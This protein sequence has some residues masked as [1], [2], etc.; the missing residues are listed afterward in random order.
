MSATDVLTRIPTKHR[1]GVTTRQVRDLIN[2][3]QPESS[4]RSDEERDPRCDHEHSPT[5]IQLPL[6]ERVFAVRIDVLRRRAVDILGVGDDDDFERWHVRLGWM[7]GRGTSPGSGT[8]RGAADVQSLHNIGCQKTRKEVGQAQVD[9]PALGDSMKPGM[10][11]QQ[12]VSNL[13]V[14]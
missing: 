12:I 6:F 4:E 11:P 1:T 14:P 10:Y 5:G 9:R 8:K 13:H 2:W 3:N 7:I